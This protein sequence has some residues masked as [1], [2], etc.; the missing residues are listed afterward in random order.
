MN[1]YETYSLYHAL[2]LHFTSNYDYFKYNAKSK[3]SVESFEKRKDKYYFYKL[4]RQFNDKEDLVVFLVANFLDNPKKWIGELLEDT[5][6][7][8][9]MARQKVLQALKYN[10][11]ND[12]QKLFEDLEDPN[13][14]LKTDGDYP[15]LLKLYFKKEISIETICILNMVL[16][17][18]GRWKNKIEDDVKWPDECM[19]IEKYIPF[20]NI[21]V[22]EYKLILK[23]ILSERV[24]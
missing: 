22:T 9:Y 19:K 21:N 18:L 3:V 14:I 4:S 8:I 2:R 5:S 24:Y 11:T 10:F 7:D 20:L 6:F 15:D 23:K 16:N 12:C 13:A 17:F 1:A